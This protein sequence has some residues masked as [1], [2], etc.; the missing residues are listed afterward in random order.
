MRKL[1]VVEF[2]SLDG[3]YQAPGR[4]DEDREGGFEHGG[5][6]M[7]YFDEVMGESAAEGMAATDAQLFGRKT[8]EKMAAYWPNAP[9][10]DPFAQHLNAVQKYVASTTLTDPG[11]QP[12]TVIRD[13]PTEVAELKA[14]EGGT[15]TVLGSGQLVRTLTAHDLVDEYSLAVFPLTLGGGKCMFADDGVLRRLRLV[16]SKPTSTGGVLLTYRPDR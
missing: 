7:P 5:W 10:D 9:E 14:Q 12:T 13:V 6:Q 3:V 15:I 4:P 1:V 11:W 16:D 2:L 8:F